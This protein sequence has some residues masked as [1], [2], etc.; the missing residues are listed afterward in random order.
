MSTKYRE[1]AMS[2]EQLPRQRLFQLIDLPEP[3]QDF[4]LL[5]GEALRNLRPIE[6]TEDASLIVQ[7][8]WSLS[9]MHS[10]ISNWEI[11]MDETQQHWI[12][13][14]C[15]RTDESEAVWGDPVD[16]NTPL[17]SIW[18]FEVVAG[19]A[20]GNLSER[21]ASI[22]LLLEAWTDERDGDCELDRPH[23]YGAS[24]V[25]NIDVIRSIEKVVWE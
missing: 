2:P 22:L 13:W 21:D 16:E 1:V 15:T 9:P 7:G 25:L 11:G 8:E 4:A 24:G 18:Y 17:V 12:L 5:Y 19:C 20:R 14:C 3:P 10:R 6:P 23:F